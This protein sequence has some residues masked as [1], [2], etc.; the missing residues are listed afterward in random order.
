M[1]V[2]EEYSSEKITN[3]GVPQGSVLGPLLYLIYTNDIDE[4]LEK[5]NIY[6]FADD[7]ILISININ[8]EEMMKNLQHDFDILN[9]Y[10]IENEL[11]ISGEK[12]IQMDITVP[13][14]N[15]KRDKWIIKHYGNCNNL[16]QNENNK[17]CNLLCT[18]IEKKS[19]TKYLGLMIDE[20]WNFKAHI[21][22]VIKRLRQ[23]IPKLYNLKMILD[24]KQKKIVYDAWICSILRYGIE[25]YGHTSDYLIQRLQRI[26][27]KLVKGTI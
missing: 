26:Q 12:T 2:K 24:N 5:T 22:N 6:M 8:Y 17:P 19:T 20:N 1:Q 21:N 7:T 23:L 16:I 3:T 14:M 13:K 15:K 10:F 4:N 18:K 27:N 9:D 25:I 11:F